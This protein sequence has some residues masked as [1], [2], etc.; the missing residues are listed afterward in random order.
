MI[1]APEAIFGTA[2]EKRSLVFHFT[3]PR[4]TGDKVC[5]L[6]AALC[7]GHSGSQPDIPG[8]EG[9]H[10]SFGESIRDQPG[11]PGRVSIPNTLLG[12]HQ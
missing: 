12:F 2:R 3:C 9:G 4:K 10:H 1:K 7:T 5:D 6:D 11:F 8:K